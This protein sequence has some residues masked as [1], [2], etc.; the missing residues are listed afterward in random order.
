M[1]VTSSSLKPSVNRMTEGFS[2][3]EVTVILKFLNHLANDF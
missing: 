1:T 3:E 2:D